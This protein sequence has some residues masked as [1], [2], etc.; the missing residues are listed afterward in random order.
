MVGLGRI[1]MT[2]DQAPA[3][4]QLVRTTDRKFSA[5]RKP[6]RPVSQGP[7]GLTRGQVIDDVVGGQLEDL[8]GEHQVI[9]VIEG[10]DDTV[11]KGRL[12]QSLLREI[13]AVGQSI[14]VVEEEVDS[15]LRDSIRY[16]LT[17]AAR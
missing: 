12:W 17:M 10:F 6:G 3:D 4:L 15:H 1:Q 16:G 5:G 11:G 9:Q 2:M 13:G 7:L 8:S 14:L